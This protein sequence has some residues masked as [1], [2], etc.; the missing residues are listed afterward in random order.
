MY[1]VFDTLEQATIATALIGYNMGLTGNTTVRWAE[2][3]Q[4]L[5]NKYRIPKP[6]QEHMQYVV[7]YAEEEYLADWF[8]I[9]NQ[10]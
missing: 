6:E 7:G 10:E 3:Q 5:D 9:D 2:P 8:G 4:R 1:L